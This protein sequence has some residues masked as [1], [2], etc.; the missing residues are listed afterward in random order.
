MRTPD[1]EFTAR[2]ELDLG[3]IEPSLAGPRRPQDLVP[4]KELKRNFAS[5]AFPA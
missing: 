4:L 1:P 2:L 3:T 5:L